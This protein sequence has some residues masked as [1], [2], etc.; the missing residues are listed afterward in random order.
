MI[1][2]SPSR[3]ITLFCWILDVSNRAFPV[4]IEDVRTVGHLKEAIVNKKLA[5]FDNVDSDQLDLWTPLIA[6]KVKGN[7]KD[8]VGSKSQYP[9]E[10]ALPEARRLLNIFPDLGAAEETLHIV[11]GIQRA[12]QKRGL[13]DIP[14]DEAKGKQRRTTAPGILS[15]RRETVTALYAKLQELKYVHVRGTP[16]SGKSSLASL[17]IS[18]I[19]EVESKETEIIHLVGWAEQEDHPEGGGT[20]LAKR[21]WHFQE[22][23]V[24]VVD[25]AQGSYWDTM[26]WNNI[27]AIRPDSRCR[28]IT[29][30]SYGIAGREYT[31]DT[32]GVSPH[33][34]VGLDP[35]DFEGQASV[36]L[37]LN[38][39]EFDDFVAVRF[40]DHRFDASLLEAIFD[41]TNG[42]VGACE[43]FLRFISGFRSYRQ[44][45]GKADAKY[46]L[47]DF[48][49]TTEMSSLVKS[50]EGRDGVSW[51]G[52]PARHNIQDE[53]GLAET[54]RTV[55]RQGRVSIAE[56]TTPPKPL[57]LCFKK[58][59]LHSVLSPLNPGMTEFVFASR[60]HHRYVECLLCGSEGSIGESRVQGFAVS[61]IQKFSPLNLVARDVGNSTQSTPEAQFQDEFYHASIAHTHGGVISFPELGN[62]YGRIDFFIPSKKWGIELLRNGSRMKAHA[63]RF[64]QGEYGEWICKGI[65]DDYVIVD[66]RT[67]LPRDDGELA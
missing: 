5:T 6:I 30:A 64:T 59:W 4:D 26:F 32:P 19:K 24:L 17:L 14:L 55:L 63:K 34:T 9:E 33:N 61:V 28:V 37:L 20:W 16:A 2:D 42:H 21:Q 43:D 51:R 15:S 48:L 38:K 12:G 65:L 36:G 7:L 67:N 1:T 46:T 58:G 29:L 27:K 10:T 35:I 62:K 44:L 8:A 53:E 54:F 3:M 22:G 40:I 56:L 41:L 66:F 31:G 52:L 49:S 18:H 13:S 57:D 50:V 45:Q 11:A 25:E 23:A 39:S 47:I 60:W